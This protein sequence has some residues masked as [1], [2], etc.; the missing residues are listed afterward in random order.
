M[1]YGQRGIEEKELIFGKVDRGTKG[2]TKI[3]EDS[4]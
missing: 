2:V 1:L 4:F 3:R